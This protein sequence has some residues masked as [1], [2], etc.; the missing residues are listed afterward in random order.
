[1]DHVFLGLFNPFSNRFRDLV[2]LAQAM[3]DLSVS[4]TDNDDRTEAETPST[5]DDFGRSTDMNH[6]VDK[7]NLFYLLVDQSTSSSLKIK[8]LLTGSRR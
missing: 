2:C 3:T 1:M 4:V 5:L 8:A 7:L 6:F